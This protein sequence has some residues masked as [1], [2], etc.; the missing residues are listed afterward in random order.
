MILL[1]T[2]FADETNAAPISIGGLSSDNDGTT[3]TIVD[4]VNGLEWLRWNLLAPLNYAETLAQIAPGGDYEGW[5]IAHN[6]HAQLFVESLF[7]NAANACTL[8]N[9]ELCG[10]HTAGIGKFTA[11]L[12]DNHGSRYDFAWFLSDNGSGEDVG[13]LQAD[14]ESGQFFKINEW[15]TIGDSNYYSHKTNLSISWLL[16]REVN[17]PAPPTISIF[18]FCL[19]LLMLTQVRSKGRLT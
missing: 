19:V 14:K 16:Y 1:I 3:E 4:E 5:K 7:Y 6:S 17:V 10:T 12:G 13:Y 2:L 8:T 15:G 9:N 11:L 18:G